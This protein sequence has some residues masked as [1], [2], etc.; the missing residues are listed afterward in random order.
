MAELCD[1]NSHVRA[2]EE[3]GGVPSPDAEVVPGRAEQVLPVLG[4]GQPAR[5][6]G[7]RCAEAALAPREVLAD[8]RVEAEVA[9][10]LKDRD[11]RLAARRVRKVLAAADFRCTHAGGAVELRARVERR[12]TGVGSRAAARPA[13]RPGPLGPGTRSAGRGLPR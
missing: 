9:D 11:E 8:R 5:H 6:R 7:A 12:T 4:R 13:A 1:P 2:A 3:A 10:Q